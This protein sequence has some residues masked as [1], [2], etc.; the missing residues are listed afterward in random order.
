MYP[1][2]SERQDTPMRRYPMSK[3]FAKVL[4][5]HPYVENATEWTVTFTTEFKQLAYDEYCR[6]KSMREIFSEAGLD[7]DQLG[8]KRLH[9]FRNYLM[10]KAAETAGFT[11]KRKN[12]SQ[13]APPSTEAQ[14]MQRIRE[15]EHRNAYLEQENEFLKKIQE[16]EKASGG[17]A[18]KRK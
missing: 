14:M 5:E 13:Q 11:D 7:V 3:E 10:Q 6:G 18:G 9:N 15:L 12:K 8:S 17:K 4:N 2:K 1:V 16:L